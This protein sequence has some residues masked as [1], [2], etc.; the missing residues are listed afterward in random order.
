MVELQNG[1]LLLNMRNYDRSKKHRQVAISEDG[2]STWIDQRF[3]DSLVEPICQ[4]SIRR[5]GRGILFSNPAHT[6][7]RVNMTVRLSTD[8]GMSWRILHRLHSGPSAYS[9]LAVLMDGRVGCLYERGVQ[10]PYETITLALFH[11]EGR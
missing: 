7:Q 3:D 8:E 6:D 4:A 2:G 9:D 10:H 5:A 1:N 11:P